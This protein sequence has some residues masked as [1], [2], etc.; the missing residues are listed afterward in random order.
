[1]FALMMLV[2]LIGSTMLVE[3][4]VLMMLLTKLV[5]LF[6]CL[7]SGP[8]HNSICYQILVIVEVWVFV[9]CEVVGLCVVGMC[10]VVVYFVVVGWCVVG[11]WCSC[12]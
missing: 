1:M 8:F 2:Q 4:I 5:E 7:L 10:G 12:A 9:Y 6:V 11:L 3:L